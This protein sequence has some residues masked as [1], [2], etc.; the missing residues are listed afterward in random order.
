MMANW[1]IPAVMAGSRRTAARV[2]PG[3]ICLSSSSHFPLKLYSNCM[4]PV[5][6]PPGYARLSTNPA[7][8]G[9][10]DDS[11]YDW[12]GAGRLQHLRHGR[13]TRGEDRLPGR[14][15]PIPLHIDECGRHRRRPGGRR[16]GCGSQ[17]D[18][19]MS[20]ARTAVTSSQQTTSPSSNSH[21]SGD[22]VDP[23]AP[24]HSRMAQLDASAH[25][26]TS[27]QRCAY[28]IE[29]ACGTMMASKTTGR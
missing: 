22:V 23:S 7:P 3:A 18:Q 9:Y 24:H 2:T 5:A 13:G 16:T 19:A 11:E 28:G 21:P 8:T 10:G 15:R 1:P 27:L 12:Y 20:A 17:R 26:H 6:L 29:I 14:A 4:K 25:R